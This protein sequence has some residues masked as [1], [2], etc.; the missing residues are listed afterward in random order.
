MVIVWWVVTSLQ[1]GGRRLWGEVDGV[2]SGDE[3]GLEV[4]N[5]R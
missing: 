5:A 2:C 3:V 4:R 1:Y